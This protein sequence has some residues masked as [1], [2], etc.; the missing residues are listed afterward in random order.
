MEVWFTGDRRT[1]R[2]SSQV[3]SEHF[4][5]RLAQD[6]SATV[7]VL[8]N[9]DYEG[10]NPDY[11]ATVDGPEV[12]R[13][14]VEALA[15]AGLKAAVWDVSAQ[16]VPHDLGVLD[17]FKAVVWYL[18]DNRLT[19]DPEDELT[20]TFPSDRC[21]TCRS[22]NGS[23]TSPWPCATISTPAASWPSPARRPATTACSGR[24]WAGSTTAWTAPPT[25]T[26]SSPPTS[27]ATA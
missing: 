24:P 13:T 11:P 2:G 4:T 15:A 21:R 5:Y 17:H 1:G 23:S 8:A 9:E 12:R 25:R 19:Q 6:S 27:S 22:P 14:Y 16:G 3:E 18:G 26:A 10:V 7:L 20:D